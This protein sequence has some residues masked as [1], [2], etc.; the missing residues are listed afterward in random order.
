MTS[1][2]VLTLKINGVTS[3]A[4]ISVKDSSSITSGA[5]HGETPPKKALKIRRTEEKLVV[6]KTIL[7]NA[8]HPLATGNT[9]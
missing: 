3:Y 7:E 2:L 6:E 5:P 1:D 4:V 8:K 9:K